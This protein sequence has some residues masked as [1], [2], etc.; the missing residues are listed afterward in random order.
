MGKIVVTEFISLDGV[1]EAP[2]GED[3]VHRNWTST[4]D[5]GDD[6]ERFKVDEA[7]GA[8]AL[9]IG[10]RTYESFAAAWPHVDGE[11]GDKYNGMPKYVV[12]STLTDPSWNNTTVL[13]GDVI[14][15][16]TALKERIVGEIQVPGSIQLVQDLIEHDVVD[17]LR[18]MTYPLVLGTGRRLIER[19]SDMSRWRLTAARTVGDGITIT[20]FERAR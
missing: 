18:L 2:G 9:L 13:S 14:A 12:S 1:V 19:T 10:R 5:R 3:F 6:G 17:E 8:E 4:V 7:L 11:L 15:E 20:T 16:T